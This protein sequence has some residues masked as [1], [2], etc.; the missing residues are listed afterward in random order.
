ML[1]LVL[2]LETLY[3]WHYFSL[4]TCSRKAYARA[5]HTQAIIIKYIVVQY[6]KIKLSR[7][8]FAD[9]NAMLKHEEVRRVQN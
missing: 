7:M 2:S 6:S 8:I 4:V 9:L 5:H 3:L 1:S